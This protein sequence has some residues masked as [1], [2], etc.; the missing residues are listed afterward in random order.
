MAE[1]QRRSRKGFADGGNV[2]GVDIRQ[3]APVGRS[4][5]PPPSR[6]HASEVAAETEATAMGDIQNAAND[7]ADA[8]GDKT[9]YAKG[10]RV[11]AVS[12]RRLQ[13]SQ[14]LYGARKGVTR[15]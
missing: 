10:G 11:D 1:Q 13:P 5:E 4:V 3:P 6:T 8:A 15:G 14:R 12:R 2:V 9:G 7:F